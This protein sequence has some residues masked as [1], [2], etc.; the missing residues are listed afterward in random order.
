MPPELILQAGRHKAYRPIPPAA[1]AAALRDA[2]NA[3]ERG[4]WF[5]THELLE[6]AWM[7]ASELGERLRT[8]A[9]IKVAA[10]FVHRARGNRAGMRTNLAGALARLRDA[11]AE[12]ADLRPLVGA[13]EDLL[14]AVSDPGVGLETIAP[15]DLRTLLTTDQASPDPG[16]AA[17]D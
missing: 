10:A 5:E 17:G 9:L 12:G 14:L 11:T 2:L 8:Q 4:D 13:V 7:G 16:R 3:W 15:P 6:P 1:R